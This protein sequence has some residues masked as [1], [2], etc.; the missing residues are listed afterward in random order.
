MIH[1]M[2]ARFKVHKG[3]LWLV[4]LRLRAKGDPAYISVFEVKAMVQAEQ[5]KKDDGGDFWS[6]SDEEENKEK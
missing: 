6:V 4:N 3:S 5:E 1:K 2:G